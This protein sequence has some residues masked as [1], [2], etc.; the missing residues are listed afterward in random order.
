MK[1]TTGWHIGVAIPARNEESLLPRCLRSVRK[2]QERV[3]ALA[4]V[5]VVVVADNCTD[6]TVQV[7]TRMLEGGG[8]AVSIHAGVVGAARATAAQLLLERHRGSRERHWIANTDADCVVPPDW[9][10]NQLALAASG[11]EAIA[12]VVSVDQFQEFGPDMP[13]KFRAS[14]LIEAGGG[15]PHVHGANLGV[16]ADVY[17]GAGGWMPLETAEDHDLW[18]RLAKNGVRRL[19]TSAITVETSGRRVGR[20]PRGFADALIARDGT[21]A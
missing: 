20:A 21:A 4:T 15:H 12:G 19:S 10:V 1:S 17:V 14:Y 9:L 16:R 11:I 2:A 18:Q 5:D 8:K 6:Q 7:A 3:R 13:A